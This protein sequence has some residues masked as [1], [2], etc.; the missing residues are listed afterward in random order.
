M[1]TNKLSFGN[2]LSA[3][4]NVTK[5]LFTYFC[6]CLQYVCMYICVFI[7][8]Y[9]NKPFFD[10]FNHYFHYKHFKH[11]KSC[12]FETYNMGHQLL[13]NEFKCV[14]W[15]QNVVFQMVNQ[16]KTV[17]LSSMHY[18]FEGSEVYKTLHNL[19]PLKRLNTFFINTCPI[20]QTFNFCI[21]F[22]LFPSFPNKD[23]YLLCVLCLANWD[24]YLVYLNFI[25]LLLM[26][27]LLV[28]ASFPSRFG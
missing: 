17:I 20:I 10:I 11:F 3:H 16:T 6:I 26:W 28:F 18:D 2:Y 19:I 21:L 14:K 25:S 15:Q 22:L 12:P 27:L 7:G 13:F 24:Q 1:L 8:H 23:M 9:S 5:G 4:S